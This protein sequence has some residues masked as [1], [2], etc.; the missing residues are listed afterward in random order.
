[1]YLIL[2]YKSYTPKTRVEILKE[3]REYEISM[4]NSYILPRIEEA[5]E[6]LKR[7]ETLL[8]EKKDGKNSQR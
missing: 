2:R 4:G 7:Q 6:M 3:F 1:L 8:E 5:I